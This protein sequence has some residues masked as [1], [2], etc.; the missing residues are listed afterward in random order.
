MNLPFRF[1]I[2]EINNH[3]ST[4]WWISK[5]VE[6]FQ[7]TG[8]IIIDGA[9]DR[10][11]LA[12]QRQYIQATLDDLFH[13]RLT[14]PRLGEYLDSG[15]VF[16]GLPPSL[17]PQ[18]SPQLAEILTG[19][20]LNILGNPVACEFFGFNTSCPGS[21]QQRIHRDV[22]DEPINGKTVRLTLN[23]PIVDFSVENGATQIWPGTHKISGS[24]VNIDESRVADLESFRLTENAG[25]VVMRDVRTWH[26]GMT[27]HTSRRRTML[28]VTMSNCDLVVKG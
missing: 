26:C 21:V 28:S 13:R 15:H 17:L 24:E 9:Y 25:A 5:I 20:I 6:T 11:G 10:L 7:T 2:D 4:S 12:P 16:Q 19:S 14:D 27:N 22:A 3:Q 18:T 1:T 8:V 23:I